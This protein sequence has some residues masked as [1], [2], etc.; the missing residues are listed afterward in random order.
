MRF[1]KVNLS[2]N[3]Y[4]E[5]NGFDNGFVLKRNVTIREAKYIMKDILG[6]QILTIDDFQ[7]KN[8]YI[9]YN[10]QL[11]LDV[12]CWLL[13]QLDDQIIM[14]YAYDCSDEPIGIWNAFKIAEYLKLRK[15]I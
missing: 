6:I 12:N 15:I 5:D 3:V 14:D 2:F 11:A 7:D 8:E 10:R 4:V 1:R 9:D 13:G